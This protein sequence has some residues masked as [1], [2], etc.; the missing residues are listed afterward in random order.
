M[1]TNFNWVKPIRARLTFSATLIFCMF[2]M[3]GESVQAQNIS[4]PDL[5]QSGEDYKKSSSGRSA[6]APEWKVEKGEHT[7]A[8]DISLQI[9][10][11]ENGVY[12]IQYDY[13]KEAMP[14]PYTVKHDYYMTSL[15]D[16]GVAVDI[17]A[18]MDHMDLY[19]DESVTLKYN[20]DRV[21][22]PAGLDKGSSIEEVNGEFFMT[23]EGV[24]DFQK[25]YVVRLSNFEILGVKKIR[26]NGKDHNAYELAY[27]YHN[28]TTYRGSFVSSKAQRVVG[29]FI[30]DLGFVQTSRKGS[31]ETRGHMISQNFSSGLKSD[32]Q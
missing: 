8:G 4:F 5:P 3:L 17:N 6:K 29:D 11:H 23:I 12:H 1:S 27:D 16:G 2:C 31:N 14:N 20:G 7:E 25:R 28:E 26:L 9:L 10:S 19:L 18:F 15:A 30:P 24:E 13:V 22:I 32:N 21:I